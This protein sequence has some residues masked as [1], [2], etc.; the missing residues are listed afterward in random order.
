M[1]EKIDIKPIEDIKIEPKP[2]KRPPDAEI[3][4]NPNKPIEK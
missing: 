2:I 3:P 1:K 4:P